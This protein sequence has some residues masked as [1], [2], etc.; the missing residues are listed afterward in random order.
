MPSGVYVRTDATRAAIGR[1]NLKHGHCRGGKLSREYIS[2]RGAWQRCFDPN[3][4][5]WKNYGERGIKMCEHWKEDF[6]AF[7]RDMGPKP[8]RMSLERIDNNLGYLCPKCC[9]P[10]G[11]CC[12]ATFSQ[13]VKNQRHKEF[14]D[15]R[16]KRMTDWWMSQTEEYRKK[17]AT[18]ASRAR[19][20]KD[21]VDGSD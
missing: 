3:T 9:P 8:N 2:W 11:N 7:L 14:H 6:P 4:K 16:S 20:K 19:H 5:S 21:G 18:E 13:Q 1:A 17:R 12:W 15:K 10:N